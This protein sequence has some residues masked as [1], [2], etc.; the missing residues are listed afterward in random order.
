M[1][2]LKKGLLTRAGFPKENLAELTKVSVPFFPFSVEENKTPD[3]EKSPKQ[4]VFEITK[5][6]KTDKMK[7]LLKVVLL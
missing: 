3:I 4:S 1:Y 2:N 7:I 5:E 6:G